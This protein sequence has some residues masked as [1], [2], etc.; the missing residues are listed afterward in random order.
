[1][2]NQ[3]AII[4]CDSLIYSAFH[5]NKVI[6]EDKQPIKENGKFVYYDK[7]EAQIIES[8]DYLMNKIFSDTNCIGYVPLVKGKGEYRKQWN[9]DY[10]ADRHTEPPKHWNFTKQYLIDRWN[11]TP[12]DIIETDDA[13]WITKNNI[14]DS[15]IVAI[16]SDILHGLPGTHFN[17]RKSEW[18]T[19]TKEEARLKFW[20]DFI[21]GTHNNVKGIP[22]KGEKYVEKLFNTE[23]VETGIVTYPMLVL[24]EFINYY[25]EEEGVEQFYRHF[26]CLRLLSEFSEFQIPS[27]NLINKEVW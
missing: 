25:G 2:N 26:K 23:L 27:V 21:I 10:K 12:V 9:N 20:S 18:V 3:I 7:T 15:F 14:D 17:W 6:G 13:V 22:K 8:C 16:D 24:N 4:D 11:A 19:T 1:M 5:P